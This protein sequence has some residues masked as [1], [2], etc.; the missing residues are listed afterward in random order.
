[1]RWPLDYAFEEMNNISLQRH[2]EYV[3]AVFIRLVSAEMPELN[4]MY[5]VAPDKLEAVNVTA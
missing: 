2:F 3:F 1:M 4:T 5:E